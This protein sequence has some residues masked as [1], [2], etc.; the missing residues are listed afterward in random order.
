MKILH[1]ANVIGE[2]K[3]GGVHEV[4]SNFYRFQKE[5]QHEPHIWYPG[6]D[7][8]AESIRLD[9]NIRGMPTYGNSNYGLIKDLFRHLPTN[10]DSFDIIHQHGVWMPMS[11]YSLKIKRNTKLKS[12][13][14][15][16]GYLEPFALS[17][18]KYKKQLA[19]NLFEKSNLLSASVL[20][21]CAKDEALKLK[22]IFPQKEI[23]IVPN[24]VSPDFFNSESKNDY[25][26]KS[27][28]RFL[29]LSQINPNKGLERL[30]RIMSSIGSS[31]FKNW[32]LIIAGYENGN[33]TEFLKELITNLKLSDLVRFVGPKFGQEKVDLFDSS[34]VFIL[35]SYNENY[36]IVIA[37]ALARGVP[38]LTTKGTPWAELSTNNCGFWIDNT[39]EGIKTGL[40][41]MLETSEKE[42]KEMGNRGKELVRQKYLWNITT[43]KTIELYQWVV[44]GGR[45]PDF[46]I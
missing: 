41:T 34:D 26:H 11:L 23:A 2:H 31:K 35:P 25:L 17:N 5:L 8:D 18:S 21:A 42:L 27:K 46:F 19:Y 36:G 38:V 12:V 7:L 10:M 1:L 44:N 33:H 40:M 14:Q 28:Q 4:V 15:P 39:E 22:K 45:K 6:S 30:F 37:E 9:G 32:E 13:I 43:V 24:G 3:G 20:V 16:H 29:F